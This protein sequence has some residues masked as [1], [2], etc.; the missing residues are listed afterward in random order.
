MSNTRD[1]SNARE[2]KETLPK[3]DPKKDAEGI[4]LIPANYVKVWPEGTH[5]KEGIYENYKEVHNDKWESPMRIYEFS[6]PDNP[7][8]RFSVS[9]DSVLHKKMQD[10]P[11][12]CLCWMEWLGTA[13][14]DK[15][16]EGQDNATYNMWKVL[17]MAPGTS[18]K[19]T[20]EQAAQVNTVK[21]EAIKPAS[22]D[23]NK[24]PW[25]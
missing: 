25:D 21:A 17:Y 19:A 4:R 10:I 3:W 1:W 9:A 7:S 20:K 16:K 11:V 14:K 18:G 12:G 23:P 24:L 15:K 8:D 2:A 5:V 6:N 13:L 22:A